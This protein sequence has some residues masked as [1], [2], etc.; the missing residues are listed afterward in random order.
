[1]SRRKREA[2]TTN[3]AAV[4]R[5]QPG[6]A[7]GWKKFATAQ[8]IWIAAVVLL[9]LGLGVAGAV[10]EKYKHSFASGSTASTNTVASESAAAQTGEPQ[11]LSKE[12]IYAGSRL[13]AV[14]D[15]NA[16][17]PSTAN[18]ISGRVVYGTTSLELAAKFVPGVAITAVANN[19][20]AK[21][22]F[23]YTDSSGLYQHTELTPNR[24]YT[25]TA[26]K[27]SIEQNGAFTT[28]I[29]GAISAFDATL[30]LREVAANGGILTPNQKIAADTNGDGSISPYDASRILQ[31]VANSG[32][33]SFGHVGSWKFSPASQNYPFSGNQT[34][35]N[36]DGMVVGDV[37]GSWEAPS[38]GPAYAST[39]Y[40]IS[41]YP[42][43]MTAL[44]GS[45]VQIPIYFSNISGRAVRNFRFQFRFDQSVLYPL[46]NAEVVTTS[47]TL[48]SGCQIFADGQPAGG[49]V[50]VAAN[51]M[52][53][54]ISAGSGTLLYLSF[55]VYGEAD[56]ETGWSR[57]SFNYSNDTNNPL[58]EDLQGNRIWAMPGGAAFYVEPPLEM[59]AAE[60]DSPLSQKSE[61]SS[62]TVSGSARA[63]IEPAEQQAA[64]QQQQPNADEM[65]ISLPENVAAPQGGTLTIPVALTNS[66]GEGL[67]AFSFD[68][69]FNPAV[70]KAVTGAAIEKTGTL[71]K[72]CE[73]VERVI[74][75]GRVSLAGACSK[76]ITAQ[77][78]TLLKLRFSVVGQ[79]G[80][81]SAEARA[82][83]FKRV[84]VFENRHGRKIGVGRHNGSIR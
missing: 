66:A 76:D 63:F 15:A 9:L 80:N 81:A 79:P 5:K 47:G 16:P 51:C 12:Y 29:N 35:V 53:S 49:M 31:F 1:M 67:S 44:Q 6:T 18:I 50:D 41:M 60:A 64:Q 70:L 52:S 61:E 13:L 68:V 39:T 3:V 78:G 30:V 7:S 32:M 22:G 34:G 4:E 24:N 84:P 59:A 21:S 26:R 65:Q 69:Q 20:L 54:P 42:S 23:T 28:D 57:L 17:V 14:E 37:N 19:Q 58:F 75:A 77:A 82:L 45:T 83:K 38:N 36:Y 33:G 8:Q 11:Q 73:V 46:S 40:S 62:T 48:S 74:R 72:D 56:T 2:V 71:A 27:D 10:S 43:D 25:L 55:N